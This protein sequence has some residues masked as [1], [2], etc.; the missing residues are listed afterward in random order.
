MEDK[1][2]RIFLSEELRKK[3]KLIC[4]RQNISMNEKIVEAIKQI[5]KNEK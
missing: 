3:L 2:F 1:V 4:V 5:V